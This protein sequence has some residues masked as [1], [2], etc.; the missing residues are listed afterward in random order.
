MPEAEPQSPPI[1]CVDVNGVLDTYS[2]WRGADHFDAPRQGPPGF[3]LR[4]GPA[5]ARSSSSPPGARMA[6]GDGYKRRGWL[7]WSP[8]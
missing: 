1:V 7:D 6:C 4:S 3:F 8:T 2:G 5:A